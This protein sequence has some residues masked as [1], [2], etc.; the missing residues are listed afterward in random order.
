M[1]CVYK[2]TGL[3]ACNEV[4]SLMSSRR[5]IFISSIAR[6]KVSGKSPDRDLSQFQQFSLLGHF[7]W[8]H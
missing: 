7:L 3:I 6:A 5:T 2:I 4:L 8:D 1:K